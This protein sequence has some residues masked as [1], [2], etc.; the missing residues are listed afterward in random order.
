M[1]EKSEEIRDLMEENKE[2]VQLLIGGDLNG[3]KGNRGGKE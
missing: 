1:K 2:K 3:R